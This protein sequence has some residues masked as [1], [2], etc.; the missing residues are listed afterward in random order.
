MTD[1]D[2]EA[3]TRQ[4]EGYY[5]EVDAAFRR[6][7]I[8]G[9]AR[10]LTDDF[11][12]YERG[13][14]KVARAET[15]AGFARMLETLRDIRWERKVRSLRVEG[16]RATATVHGVF[17]AT[18]LGA[19]GGPFAFDI[20]AEDVWV[21]SGETWKTQCARSLGRHEVARVPPV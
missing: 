2:H 17:E 9:I 12:A 14:T 10:F 1:P 5:A 13:G 8:Q 11:V 21:R 15:V 4:L 3:L 19:D 18:A 20:T 16:D 6:K 7:D